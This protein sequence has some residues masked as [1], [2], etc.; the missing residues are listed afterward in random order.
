MTKGRY[1]GEF[2]QLVMLAL[3]RLKDDAYGVTIRR[4]IES[5]TGRLVTIGSV[6]ATLERL[7]LKAYVSYRVSVSEPR[8]GGR[9]K[10]FF[11]LTPAGAA[12][13]RETRAM[14][15]RMAAGMDLDDEL[16]VT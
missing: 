4:E 16:E 7:E 15:A 6:Y 5:R 9:W 3:I 1:L 8:P 10:K 11:S 12:A 13:M 14:V 2:E